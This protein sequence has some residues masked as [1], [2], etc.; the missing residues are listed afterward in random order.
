L[1]DFLASRPGLDAGHPQRQ[2]CQG[3]LPSSTYG[4][5]CR[6]SASPSSAT[7]LPSSSDTL[8]FP[9]LAVKLPALQEQGGG[10]IV[11]WIRRILA[12]PHSHLQLADSGVPRG[13]LAPAVVGG[14]PS[15]APGLLRMEALSVSPRFP[16]LSHVDAWLMDHLA[17]GSPTWAAPVNSASAAT[18][19]AEPWQMLS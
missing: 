10:T 1:N 6:L 7:P 4:H 17:H 8:T 15:A 16:H 5:A 11:P 19:Q 9:D 12:A 2:H 14:Y 13:L 3:V 18:L